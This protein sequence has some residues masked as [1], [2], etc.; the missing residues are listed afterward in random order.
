MQYNT[1]LLHTRTPQTKVSLRAGDV[2]KRIHIL[3]IAHCLV[4]LL[5]MRFMIILGTIVYVVQL[6][7]AW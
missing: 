3:R 6:L 5:V 7:E 1:H 2:I 4:Q